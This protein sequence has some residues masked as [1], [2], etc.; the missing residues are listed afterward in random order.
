MQTIARI[1]QRAILFAC[2]TAAGVYCVFAAAQNGLMVAPGISGVVMATGFSAV[3]VASWFLLSWAERLAAAQHRTEAWVVRAGWG[4]ALIFVLF[5]SVMF[6]AGHRTDMTEGAGLKIEAYADAREA[7]DRAASE[8]Q[9]LKTNPRWSATAGCSNATA[10]RSKAFCEQVQSTV[11]RMDAAVAIIANG[12]PGSK[13]AGAE[14]LSW[15]T[16]GAVGANS[17]GKGAPLL[18]ALVLELIASLCMKQA[19]KELGANPHGIMPEQVP[20]PVVAEILPPVRE[21]AEPAAVTRQRLA[22]ALLTFL[23]SKDKPWVGQGALA[24][25]VGSKPQSVSDALGKLES[26]GHIIRTLAE[27]GRSNIIELASRRKAS[28]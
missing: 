27:D 9:S 18:W 6:A 10:E 13:D 17:I 19:F 28:A 15:L 16:G 4:L 3:V 2:G 11:A 14:S 22:E 5:N 1:T 12:R 24:R 8:L 26:D 23:E 7:K 21:E 20:I 25:E